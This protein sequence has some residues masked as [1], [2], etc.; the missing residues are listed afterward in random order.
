MIFFLR[1]G[2]GDDATYGWLAG[3]GMARS[4]RVV[5]LYLQQTFS[6]RVHESSGGFS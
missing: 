1:G 5:P 3:F 6:G 2:C 4:L